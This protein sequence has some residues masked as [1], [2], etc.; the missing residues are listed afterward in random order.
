MNLCSERRDASL[1]SVISYVD[2]KGPGQ[3]YVMGSR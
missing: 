3:L 2:N 1:K